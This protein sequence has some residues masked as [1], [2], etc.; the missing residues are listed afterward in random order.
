MTSFAFPAVLNEGDAGTLAVVTAFNSESE[1]P[2]YTA[3]EKH[4]HFRA[5]LQ[6][7]QA[8]DP[9]VWRLFDVVTGGINAFNAITERVS[10]DGEQ[11]LWDGDP[12]HSTL[13]DQLVR[14][15]EDGNHENYTALARFWEKLESNP[16]DHSRTQAYD[17]LSSH[18]F[19]ITP[20]G[21]VVAFKGMDSVGNNTYESVW[22][23]QVPDVPSGYV[24]G[25]PIKERSQ[26][27]QK[28][29][30]VITMPRSEV[31]HNP[32]VAC[33][34]GLHVSTRNYAAG[35]S[36]NGAILEVHVNPR[37]IVSVPTDGRGAKVRTCRYFI[38]RIASSE[39][40]Y[41]SPVLRA[42]ETLFWAGDVGYTSQR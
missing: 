41:E 13:S 11:V 30:D 34:R 26:I 17:W 37:D 20:E 28:V 5:I 14:A 42:E 4:P 40:D 8:G 18:K 16:N 32:S 29:G 12:V 36:R 23:S 9:G 21:D 27:P 7:L 25:V 35:Y 19:Q 3:D 38:A 1:T 31:A 22:A 6:G 15:I 39:E 24:N 33:A 2:V 10:Y